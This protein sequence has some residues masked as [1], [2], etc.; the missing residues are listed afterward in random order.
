[1]SLEHS[2]SKSPEYDELLDKNEA[3]K[4]L[5]NIGNTKFYELLNDGEIMAV[6]IGKS[7]KVKRSE[8]S[9]YI[10]TLPAYGDA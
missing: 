7:L 3:R 10:S 2:P 8:I 5:G 9:R 1:M 4:A 6:K